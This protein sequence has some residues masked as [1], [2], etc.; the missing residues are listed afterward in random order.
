MIGQRSTYKPACLCLAALLLS[1][2][3]YGQ[4][5]FQVSNNVQ[6]SV[7]LGG[8]TGLGASLAGGDPHVLGFDG[9]WFDFPGKSGNVYNMI[10]HQQY[11]VNAKFSNLGNDAVENNYM[12]EI[13]IMHGDI[14]FKIMAAGEGKIKVFLDDTD[15]TPFMSAN[16]VLRMPSNKKI[17]MAIVEPGIKGGQTFVV[18]L[19]HITF[20]VFSWSNTEWLDVS[21]GIHS[22]LVQDM[23]GI[24]GQT[25]QG[26]KPLALPV[27]G[28]QPAVEGEE[29]NYIVQD[30]LW[31]IDFKF[32]L[33]DASSVELSSKGKSHRRSTLTHAP[34]LVA[35]S[36]AEVQELMNRPSLS[37]SG[38]LRYLDNRTS[39]LRK[40]KAVM[41]MDAEEVLPDEHVF[42]S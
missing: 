9:M 14:K 32:N 21:T 16:K 10:S 18:D 3:V 24:I 38:T 5:P 36:G 40:L 13:T 17:V 12:T 25:W 42:S 22:E 11:Q 28:G 15:F 6:Q 35:A 37:V 26:G 41:H 33:Y 2:S 27:K 7:Q 31:G 39:L 34:M 30:G 29:D 1:S 4:L 23:H 19:P 20:K 8:L